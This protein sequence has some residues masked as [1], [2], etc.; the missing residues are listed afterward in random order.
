MRDPDLI[1]MHPPCVLRFRDIP[2]FPGPISDVVPSSSV[3]ELYPIGFLTMSEYLARHGLS[4]RIINLAVKM[5]NHPGLDPERFIAGLRPAA[6]GIDLHWLTHADGALGLAELIKRRHPRVPVILGGLSATYYRE[7]IMRDYPWVDFIL[8]GDSTEE[9][10]RALV[11]AIKAGG[12]YEE[13]PNLTWRE[14]GSARHNP[15]TYR[16][17]DLDGLRF[18]YGHLMKMAVRHKDPMGYIPFRDWPRYPVTSV[19]SVRGCQHNCASCGGSHSAFM[20]LCG[21]EG[22]CYRSPELLAD[23]ILGISR[24]TSAPVMV[25]GDLLQAGAEYADRFL[26]RMARHRVRNEIAIEF[27]SPPPRDLM[28]RVAAAI[29]NF[30]VEISPESHDPAVREAFGKGYENAALEEAARSILEAGA[31]RLDLFFMVGLPGQDYGSVMET[32]DYCDE[33]L[34]RFGGDGR[35]LPMIAPLAP[36]IDPGSRIFESPESF[37]YRIFYRTLAE[38]RRAMLMPSW[39]RSL[40]YETSWMSRDDIVAA[41]YDGATR[42]VGIKA[43]RGLLGASRADDIRD[44]IRKSKEIMARIDRAGAADEG[45]RREMWGL[46][47]RSSICDKRELEW[48]LR[49]WRLVRPLAVMKRIMTPGT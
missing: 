16:P 48:P 32:V 4:V 34:G 21:R 22:P 40:N 12:G 43:A 18:D 29:P 8:S 13:V 44:R 23:D 49:R 25:L 24:Y 35:L 9:P 30:N 39:K 11:S 6:F 42:L 45:L 41:T 10:L 46:F 31:R 2:F 37:G 3:F 7:E 14:G 47:N 27:F 28:D 20:H 36:F 15:M 38:H 17:R 19:F 5:L 26:A 33:L 1:L